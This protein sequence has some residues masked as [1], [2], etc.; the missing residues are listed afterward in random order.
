MMI[1]A[2]IE[3]LDF[4]CIWLN[5]FTIIIERLERQ[6]ILKTKIS[7]LEPSSPKAV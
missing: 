5:V 6:L 1:Y 4:V 7:S 2:S 3:G